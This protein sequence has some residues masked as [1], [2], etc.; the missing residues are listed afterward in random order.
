MN[1]TCDRCGP[2]VRVLAAKTTA[3]A[4]VG[5]LFGLAA[6][7]LATG[8]TLAFV[9]AKGSHLALAAATIC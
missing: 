7:V 2:A 3:D 8:I 4:G 6:A 9:A 5:L 1:Q